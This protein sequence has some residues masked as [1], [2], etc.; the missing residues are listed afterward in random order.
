MTCLTERMAEV[1]W[2]LSGRGRGSAVC[3]TQR[4]PG[5]GWSAQE[6]GR[7]VLPLD[8][9]Q[10]DGQPATRPGHLLPDVLP[11]RLAGLLLGLAGSAAHYWRVVDLRGLQG[12]G[13]RGFPLC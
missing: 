13:D 12:P 6:G 5:F 4:S 11:G 7:G 8:L 10:L 1:V 9:V 3:T 2:L